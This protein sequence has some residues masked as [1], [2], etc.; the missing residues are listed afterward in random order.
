MSS[1]QQPS[2]KSTRLIILC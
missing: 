1:K 2:D